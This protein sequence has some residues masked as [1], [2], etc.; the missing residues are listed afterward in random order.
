MLLSEN[1]IGNVQVMTGGKPSINPH[2]TI[3]ILFIE[4]SCRMWNISGTCLF[5]SHMSG[6]QKVGLEQEMK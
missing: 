2:N 6:C 5:V 1:A 3:I 4:R